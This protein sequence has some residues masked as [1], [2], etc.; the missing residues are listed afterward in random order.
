VSHPKDAAWY[1][2][3][4]QERALGVSLLTVVGRVSHRTAPDLATA[5]DSAAGSPGGG[6]VLDLT[7]V[8]Y[9]SSAG[10]RAVET[11]AARMRAS[12]RGLVVCGLRDAVSVAFDLAGLTSAVAVEESREQA[13]QKAGRLDTSLHDV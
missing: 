6:L 2:N 1:L 9:I 7:G 11:A 10:L 12:G 13:I 4:T 3:I 5:L 8:D